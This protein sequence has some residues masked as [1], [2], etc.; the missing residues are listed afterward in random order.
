MSADPLTID[1]RIAIYKMENVQD[2]RGW[3]DKIPAISF[4]PDWEIKII[5]PF[6]GAIVRFIACKGQH[7]VS[8]YMDGYDRL[9]FWNDPYWEAYPHDGDV[10]RC[11]LADTDGLLNAIRES[12]EQ[13]ETEAKAA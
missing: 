12:F 2:Y 10:F 11:A 13:M 8:V 1:D 3:I 6:G 4:P 5:P 7:S 9:G